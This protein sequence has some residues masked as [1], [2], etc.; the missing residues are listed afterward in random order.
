MENSE[1]Q[2]GLFSSETLVLDLPDANVVYVPGF[3]K[4]EA[5]DS[6][7]EQVLGNTEWRQDQVTVFGKRH[8]TPRL[9]CW[10]GD[11]GLSYSYSNTTMISVAWTQALL[12]VR[13][14]LQAFTGDVFNS[15]LINYYRDGQDSNGWHSDDEPELGIEPVIASISLGAERDFHL[16][17]KLSEQKQC[18]KL[19]HG[20]LLMMR[21][22]TQQY[23]QHHVPKRAHADRRINLTFRMVK[24]TRKGDSLL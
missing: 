11:A 18:I 14:G 3:Y 22:T 20:S 5:A 12:R 7:F 17:H 24:N 10:M 21:G 1:N 19:E 2:P 23:W 15:V 4:L 16:R 6:L 9:S 13:E 8:L